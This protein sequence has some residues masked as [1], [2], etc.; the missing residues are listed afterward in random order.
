MSQVHLLA[1]F[2]CVP[3]VVLGPEQNKWEKSS[4]RMRG[5]SLST[6]TCFLS[7]I[8]GSY[9]LIYAQGCSVCVCVCVCIVL[10]KANSLESLP[11]ID[12]TK[13]YA[14]LLSLWGH[15]SFDDLLAEAFVDNVRPINQ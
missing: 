9:T 5:E 4:K 15:L 2:S 7:T 1:H 3:G 13:P 12:Q 14:G 8:L 11:P 10:T 6:L